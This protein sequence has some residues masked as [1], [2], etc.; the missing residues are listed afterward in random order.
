[1]SYQLMDHQKTDVDRA[2]NHNDRWLFA[3]DTGT[4]KTLIG[5]EAIKQTGYKTLVIC[6][7]AII[8][9][10]WMD[11]LNTFYP[12]HGAVNLWR[13]RN[14][15]KKL[16]RAINDAPINIINFESFKTR[17]EYLVDGA[18]DQV[19]IDESSWVK[20]HKAQITRALTWFCDTIPKTYLFSGNPAPNSNQEYFSQA[21][22]VDSNVFGKSF[23]KFRHYYFYQGGYNNYQWF[24]KQEKI[25]EFQNKLAQFCSVVRK[26]DVLDLPPRTF[27]I[28]DVILSGKE[29]AA[30]NQMTKDLVAQL[31]E[32]E[33]T[34]ANAAVKTSKLRQISSGFLL[35]EG[36]VYHLGKSKLKETLA[37]IDEIGHKKL[38]IWIDFTEE[39]RML[40]AALKKKGR[41]T[42]IIN[43][44][45]KQSYKEDAIQTFK[46]PSM[47][48]DT[49]IA[50]PKSMGHG[51][52]LTICDTM[53]FYSLGYSY[54]LYKQAIDRIYRMGT[55]NRCSYYFMLGVK[56]HDHIVYTAVQRKKDAA[57]AVLD[58]IRSIHEHH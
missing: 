9:R 18:Y 25:E 43:R 31:E 5:I 29:K 10:A 50:H 44:T 26:E 23:Y 7:L 35:N 15:K 56:T 24:Q 13:L 21:R 27:N 57:T 39:G 41:K 16:E 6:P 47:E 14:S 22:I 45:T 40:Q 53:I 42:A 20:N 3:N 46:K 55:A 28:R 2:L 37:L 17:L 8:E 49:L 36:E 19:L 58:Y 11:D 52:T 51:H 30:Y 48:I 54:D 34:A 32:G 1:M 33:I 38:I 4:G 12:G